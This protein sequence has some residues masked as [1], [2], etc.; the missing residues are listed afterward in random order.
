MF[1]PL[2]MAPGSFALTTHPPLLSQNLAWM[3]A[4][5]LLLGIYMSESR[6]LTRMPFAG[7]LKFA[8]YTLLRYC[9]KALELVIH[10]M[11]VNT[12]CEANTPVHNYLISCDDTC[13]CTDV[14]ITATTP[15]PSCFHPP[16]LYGEQTEA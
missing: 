1:I 16:G 12:S 15:A 14:M 9:F 5:V 6:Q 4:R 7:V 8:A 13:A 3:A 11:Q 10:T 2:R